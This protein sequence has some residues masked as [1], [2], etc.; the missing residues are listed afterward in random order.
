MRAG[1]SARLTRG[2]FHLDLIVRSL[3]I[4]DQA[5]ARSRSIKVFRRLVRFP[6]PEDLLVL[7]LVAGRARDL[8]DLEGIMRRHGSTMD[9]G[10]IQR[11]LEKLSDL[12]EDHAFLDRWRTL[13][14]SFPAGPSRSRRR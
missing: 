6:A 14:R 1:G 13:S 12:A 2:R 3:F 9:R 7:K 4:E 8:L 10:H 11:T 5:L